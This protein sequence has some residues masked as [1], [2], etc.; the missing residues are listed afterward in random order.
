MTFINMTCM[1]DQCLQ[2]R[3]SIGY[4]TVVRN[5]SKHLWTFDMCIVC[6]S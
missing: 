2:C 5:T 6:Y 3:G 1:D 4:V